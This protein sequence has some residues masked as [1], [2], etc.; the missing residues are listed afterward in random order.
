MSEPSKDPYQ[1]F[2]QL[3]TIKIA[4]EKAAS[5]DP[6]LPSAESAL[7]A[8]LALRSA[9]VLIPEIKDSIA[10]GHDELIKAKERLDHEHAILS[11]SRS[12]AEALENR[13]AKLRLEHDQKSQKAPEETVQAMIEEQRNCRRAYEKDTR[14]L[15]RAF[16]KFV[17]D[18]LGAMLAAE[19]LGGPVVGDLLNIAD[20]VLDAGF[21]QKGNSKKVKVPKPGDDV[22]R[23]QRIDQIWG[24][25]NSDDGL[26]YRSEREAASSEMRMLTEDLLNAAAG[27][28]SGK[29]VVLQRESAAA[30]F[31]VRA[32]VAQFHPR[33]ARKLCLVEFER[34]LED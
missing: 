1:R 17:N 21:T 27:G 4:Y 24:Q 25:S 22:R 3:R 6:F 10:S 31:L 9:R 15:I 29:Y 13:I 11:D 33:D 16:V 30:R 8:L 28:T 5:S 19:E 7:P 20:E 26:N 34:E 18:H 32:K 14:K 2:R 23:Q 12:L